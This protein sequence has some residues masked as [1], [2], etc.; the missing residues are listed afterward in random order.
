MRGTRGEGMNHGKITEK[1]IEYWLWESPEA[2]PTIYVDAKIR[3]LARQYRVPSGIIDL[4]G[5]LRGK[6]EIGLFGHVL[7]VEVKNVPID[8][9]AIAQVS[10][11]AA[12][13]QTIM[14]ICYSGKGYSGYVHPYLDYPREIIKF[15]IGR[16]PKD[17]RVYFEAD[18]LNISMLVFDEKAGTLSKEFLPYENGQ[19]TEFEI[20][21][22]DPIWADYWE[23]GKQARAARAYNESLRRK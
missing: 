12:D 14:D 4:L 13:I 11:Y 21:A 6:D 1:D 8:S 3:W 5:L 22:N 7:V 19:E 17:K 18:A 15:V 16:K 23:Y 2:I 20:L 10:R 9:K